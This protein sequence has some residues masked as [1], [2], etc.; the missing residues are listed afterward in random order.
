MYI[1]PLIAIILLALIVGFW[2]PIFAVAIAAV[3]FVAFLVYRGFTRG[4]E[5]A[6]ATPPSTTVRRDPEDNQHGIWGER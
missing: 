1:V 5:E 3:F 4:R 6:E 2:S